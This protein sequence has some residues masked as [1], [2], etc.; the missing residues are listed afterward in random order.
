[1][2]YYHSIV[3]ELQ[4]RSES[5]RDTK[6][7]WKLGSWGL[8]PMFSNRASDSEVELRFGLRAEEVPVCL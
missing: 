3:L 8:L 5:E 6:D 1:M 7:P 2:D 4:K